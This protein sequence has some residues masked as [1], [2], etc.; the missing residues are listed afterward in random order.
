MYVYIYIFPVRRRPIGY[1]SLEKRLRSEYWY[2]SREGCCSRG[3]RCAHPRNQSKI[4][5]YR[6]D[7]KCWKVPPGAETWSWKPERAWCTIIIQCLEAVIVSTMETWFQTWPWTNRGKTYLERGMGYQEDNGHVCLDKFRCRQAHKNLSMGTWRG[8]NEMR[9]K[10]SAWTRLS[11][12][13]LLMA[14]E[15]KTYSFKF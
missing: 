13:I 8:K 6:L 5:R 14:Q 12:W 15:F 3:W 1:R 11:I 2:L 7:A 9:Q 4:T 10:T